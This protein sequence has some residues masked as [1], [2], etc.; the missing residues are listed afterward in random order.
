MVPCPTRIALFTWATE[1]PQPAKRFARFFFSS[2][3]RHTSLDGVTGVQTCALP[4]YP[5]DEH[6]VG[7]VEAALEHPPHGR[8]D[9]LRVRPAERREVALPDQRR[10]GDVHRLD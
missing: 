7:P 8:A 4:I 6:R 10:G 2:R 1:R 3:R 9:G 5:V